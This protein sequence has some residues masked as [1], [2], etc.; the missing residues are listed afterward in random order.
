MNFNWLCQYRFET[1]NGRSYY[2][3]AVDTMWMTKKWTRSNWELLTDFWA[4]AFPKIQPG[5]RSW[6]IRLLFS[7]K[8][9][10]LQKW[11][12]LISKF[13]TED[14]LTRVLK[15]NS[16]RSRRRK[17]ISPLSRFSPF[18]L[19]LPFL[20]LCSTQADPR[21]HRFLMSEADWLLLLARKLIKLT[22]SCIIPVVCRFVDLYNSTEQNSADH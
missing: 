6:P 10:I 21:A 14:Y 13:K 2:T 16:L 22:S 8:Y 1:L 5:D 11:Q 18:H 7:K 20:R 9:P 17:R 15:M 3:S 19:P 4:V 12:N